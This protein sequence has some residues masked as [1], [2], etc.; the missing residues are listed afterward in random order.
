MT[1]K[2]DIWI[3]AKILLRTQKAFALERKLLDFKVK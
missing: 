1:E 3:L 2:Q